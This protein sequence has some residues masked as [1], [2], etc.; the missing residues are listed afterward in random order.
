MNN[1]KLIYSIGNISDRFVTEACPSGVL[2]RRAKIVTLLR[3]PA[4]IAAVVAAAL[5]LCAFTYYV[6]TG[7]DLWI[8]RPAKDPVETVRS[9]LE[10]QAG[11]DYT[12]SIEVKSVEVDEAETERVVERFISGVI[13]ERRGWSDEYLKDNFIVVK[14]EYYAEYDHTLTTRS[15]GDV[16]QYFYLT[17]DTRSGKWTIVDNSGNVNWSDEL[18]ESAGDAAE[19]DQGTE[20]GQETAEVPAIREQIESYL[21]ALFTEV[22]SPYYDGL[23][24]EITNYEETVQSG[25]C[26]ATF[27]WTMYH[28]GKGWDIGSDEGVE[29]QG[30]FSLQVKA[31]LDSRGVLDPDTISVL[32]DGSAVGPPDYSIPIEDFFPDQLA[33]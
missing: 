10:N 6:A 22:Y 13:A 1:E 29:Q 23:H 25:E 32:A 8:Q 15:D 4:F 21:T 7:G 27:F 19:T 17:R 18:E 12:I 5:L 20:P 3:K 24:Y 33:D 28:L 9:A 11:K 31:G 30:N 2:T 14:A 26:T 16:V